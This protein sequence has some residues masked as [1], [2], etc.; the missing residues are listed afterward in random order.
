[1]FFPFALCKQP[2]LVCAVSHYT[3]QNSTPVIIAAIVTFIRDCHQLLA[4]FDNFLYRF[5]VFSHNPVLASN[6]LEQ[7]ARQAAKKN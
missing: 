4:Q 7:K 5:A 2:D 6:L 3:V 1:M